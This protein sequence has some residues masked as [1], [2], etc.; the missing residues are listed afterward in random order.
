MI[1]PQEMIE[2]LLSWGRVFLAASLTYAAG[3]GSYD[4]HGMGIAGLAA[5][6]PVV[7]RWLDPNDPTYGKGANR[8]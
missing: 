1:N 3:T 4:L 8:G 6:V 5:I 2:M 7:I